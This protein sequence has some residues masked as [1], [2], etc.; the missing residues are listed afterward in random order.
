MEFWKSHESWKAEVSRLT[1]L[2]K[3]WALSR[4]MLPCRRLHFLQNYGFFRWKKLIVV[5]HPHLRCQDT[6]VSKSPNKMGDSWWFRNPKVPTTFLDVQDPVLI[7][8]K[9]PPS[10]SGSPRSMLNPQA[11]A[12][13]VFFQLRAISNAMS[14][15]N[16][17]SRKNDF[18]GNGKIHCNNIGFSVCWTTHPTGT[19][20]F[21]NLKKSRDSF[22]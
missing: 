10:P 20:P 22:S 18:I 11:G 1:F 12:A 5:S 3:W 19:H 14:F 2:W 4:Y 7:M 16:L 13:W 8:G 17:G 6:L 15:Y 21:R 9:L